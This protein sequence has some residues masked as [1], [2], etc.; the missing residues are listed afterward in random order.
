MKFY[1]V[2]HAGANENLLFSTKKA[3]LDWIK[4]ENN[5][6]TKIVPLFSNNTYDEHEP[7]S[8]HDIKTLH[9][10]HLNKKSI[11]LALKKISVIAGGKINIPEYD[12]E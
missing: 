6:K 12:N 5:K 8:E 3:A 2:I 11:L 4:F 9:I 10:P 7:Y 1:V